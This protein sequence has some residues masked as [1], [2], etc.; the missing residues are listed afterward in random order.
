M[1]RVKTSISL[2][3]ANKHYIDAHPEIKLSEIANKVIESMMQKANSVDEEALLS[4][5]DFHKTQLRK[6]TEKIANIEVELYR[7]QQEREQARKEMMKAEK[8]AEQIAKKEEEERLKN[9]RNAQKTA[10]NLGILVRDL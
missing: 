5:L 4:E 3:I 7:L 8:E 9:L 6:H 1:A 10:H 2:E